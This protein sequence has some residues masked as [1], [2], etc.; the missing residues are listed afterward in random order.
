MLRGSGI[1]YDLRRDQPYE[2]YDQLNF[3]VP[4]GTR[5]DCYDRYFL[6]IEEMRQSL[7]IIGQCLNKMPAGPIKSDNQKIAAPARLQM[8]Q[9]ME[10]LIHHFKLYTEGYLVPAGESFAAVEAPKGEFGVYLIANGS[11]RPYRCK[12]KAPGFLHLQGLDFMT[13]GH[14]IADV[15]TTIGTQDIVFGEVDR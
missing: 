11:S 6:R 4:V 5:G 3:Q 13:Q 10:A 12:I 7:H 2:I 1:D 14:L 15:V 9:S 8:K